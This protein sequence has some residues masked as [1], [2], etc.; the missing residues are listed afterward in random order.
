MLLAQTQQMGSCFLQRRVIFLSE[1]AGE[2]PSLTQSGAKPGGE[3]IGVPPFLLK[4]QV[5]R[6]SE[7]IK[8]FFGGQR[9]VA[10]GEAIVRNR[11]KGFSP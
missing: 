7:V 1:N 3:S 4:L 5:R 11:R 8:V 9:K 10:S 6:A 2:G